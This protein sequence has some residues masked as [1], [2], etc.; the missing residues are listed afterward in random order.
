MVQG[1]TAARMSQIC[2][3]WWDLAHATRA[4]PPRAA[5]RV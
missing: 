1:I 5:R 3:T 2:R 4:P